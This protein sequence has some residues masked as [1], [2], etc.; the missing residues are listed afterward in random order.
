MSDFVI[1]VQALVFY[2]FAF[3]LMASAF[4]VVVSRNTVHGALFLV[5]CFFC[6]SVL[7]MMLE[8]E[9]LALALIFVYVGAVMTLFLFVVMMLNM[10]T[11]PGQEGFVKYMPFGAIIMAFFVGLML[12]VI[13]PAH[14]GFNS[15]TAVK[16]QGADYSNVKELGGVLYTQYFYPFEI[17][18]VLLVV[19]IIAAI[20]LA[21]RGKQ[22]RKAQNIAKQI[23]VTKQDRL[24]LVDIK[25]EKS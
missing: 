16:L 24:R 4:M 5:L 25:P 21:F 20:T 19:A 8:A 12:Y 18:A 11:D 23:S 3:I 13:G 14:L 6:S 2:G 17:A 1:P 9:F 10:A 15:Q 7:W 22:H